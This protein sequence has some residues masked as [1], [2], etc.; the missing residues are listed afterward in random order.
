VPSVESATGIELINGSMPGCGLAYG[1]L[2]EHGK[3]SVRSSGMD[4]EHW[5]LHWR[6][7]VEEADPDVAVLLSGGWDV[8]DREVGDVWVAYG[9]PAYDEHLRGLFHR[10]S[11]VLGEA[12]IP[13]VHLTS[14]YFHRENRASA[15]KPV[16]SERWRIDRY[17]DLLREH[18]A[19]TTQAGV[20]VLEFGEW[21]CGDAACTAT[22]DGVPLRSDGSHFSHEGAKRAAAW[23]AP[24]LHAI[25]RE[26]EASAG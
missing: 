21:V 9:S 26:Q 6:R 15:M 1:R 5:D 4:C 2:R 16:V 13:V 14:A 25:V 17:N 24:R 8:F 18:A 19:S 20:F 3:I 10:A 12:G 7:Y 23:L 11:N 22:R